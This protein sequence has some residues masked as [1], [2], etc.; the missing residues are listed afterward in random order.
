MGKFN[1]EMLLMGIVTIIAG[2][3]IANFITIWFAY[4]AWRFKRN[5]K[6]NFALA[7]MIFLLCFSGLMLLAA[8]QL[9][10]AIQSDPVASQ[11]H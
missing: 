10:T 5:S 2:A 3:L 4:A 6:D 8:S 11:S 7:Q 9:Q 1:D